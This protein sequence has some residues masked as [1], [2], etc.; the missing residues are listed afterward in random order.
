MRDNAERIKRIE[1]DGHLV[2][3]AALLDVQGNG[4]QF[5]TTDTIGGLTNSVVR[6]SGGYM[7]Y[8]DSYPASAKRD[9]AKKVA[10]TEVLQSW[11]NDQVRILKERN[12]IPLQLYWA[13]SNMSNLDIDPID[14][15]H[16]PVVLRGCLDFCVFE[17]YF[18][19]GGRYGDQERDYRRV[20]EG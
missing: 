6:G 10:P 18:K 13:A 16:F 8:M 2:G 11:A 14:V 20:I 19:S 1:H 17:P 9:V 7:G 3:L 15:I 12:A 4:I 5:L